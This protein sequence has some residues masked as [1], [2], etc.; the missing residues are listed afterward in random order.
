MRHAGSVSFAAA[1]RGELPTCVDIAVVDFE[2][3]RRDSRARDR[4]PLGVPSEGA[5]GR[6]LAAR[7]R[8]QQSLRGRRVAQRVLVGDKVVGQ[9]RGVGCQPP[10]W[11]SDASGGCA[12]GSVVAV[13]VAV[14]VVDGL[15]DSEQPTSASMIVTTRSGVAR[16]IVRMLATADR[17]MVASRR[18]WLKVFTSRRVREIVCD[19]GLVG[20]QRVSRIGSCDIN[21]GRCAGCSA[22]APIRV[23]SR[24]VWHRV[25]AVPPAA[26]DRHR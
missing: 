14:V 15:V 1:H 7:R 18:L 9:V 13:A 19:P 17:S 25:A 5:V 3:R 23:L 12:G 4:V 11:G 26:V 10:F 20:P 22:R 6:L 8:H 24:D 21:G 2:E 16:R